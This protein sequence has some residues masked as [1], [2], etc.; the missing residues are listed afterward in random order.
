LSEAV[1]SGVLLVGALLLVALLLE[2][3]AVGAVRHARA[4]AS[5]YDE[6]R[7]QLANS[8]APVGQTDAYGALLAPGTPVALIQAP[9]IGLDEVVLEGTTSSVLASGPGHRRDTVL[10]GQ[11]GVSLV[12]GRRAAYGGPFAHIA[13]LSAGD[14]ITVT[15]GQGVQQFEVIG[16][17]EAGD[18]TPALA[19]GDSRLTLATAAGRPYLP[20]EVVRV[21]A[22]L[23][24]EPV[25][26]PARVFGPTALTAS[27]EL[28]A[29]DTST[30]LSL[31]LWA[32]LLLVAGVGVALLLRLWGRWQSWVVAVPVLTLCG[33]GVAHQVAMFLPNLM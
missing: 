12:F 24:S 13:D 27:E 4:Q 1:L 11:P 8:T 26:A 19:T 33:L 22:A 5:A 2:V 20:S 17:R 6:F 9:S 30:A 25:P 23:V 28:L 29:G 18:D 3:S 14:Q 7:Y 31:Y 16:V 32:Q 10:P 21:D 15:T